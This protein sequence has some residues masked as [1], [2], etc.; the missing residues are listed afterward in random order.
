MNCTPL[1][2]PARRLVQVACACAALLLGACAAPNAVLLP[3]LP[4]WFDGKLVRYV[5]TDVSHPD[6]AAMM[7]ANHAPRLQQTVPA[8]GQRRHGLERVYKVLGFEQ[9]SVFASIPA[10]LGPTS[11]DAAYSPLWRVV[12][13]QWLPGRAARE[14]RSEE[15]VLKAEEAGDLRLAV[16]DVV[17]N[18]P[19]VWVDGEPPLPNTRLVHEARR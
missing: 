7:G 6:M 10:P 18:C 3:A 2:A 14:L 13:A 1:P 17:V 11:R 8:A 12:E 4:G 9:P 15:A 19:V 16:T 5:V